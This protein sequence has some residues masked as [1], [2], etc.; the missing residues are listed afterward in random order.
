MIAKVISTP[1]RKGV[2]FAA[3]LFAGT[4]S[5]GAGGPQ[6]ALAQTAEERDFAYSLAI[7]DR[8]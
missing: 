3:A 7:C 6:A 8:G 4:L 2:A 1:A 5:L